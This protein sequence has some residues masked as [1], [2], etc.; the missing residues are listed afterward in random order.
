MVGHII[1]MILYFPDKLLARSQSATEVVD[2]MR[3]LRRFGRNERGVAAVEFALVAPVLVLLLC[4]TIAASAAF[5][6]WGMM[7]GSS[8]Y[9]A[10]IMATG[11]VKNNVSGAITT[12]NT[13]A[14]TTCSS[15]LPST[16]VEY[17]ACYNL[18]SWATF[19]VT[20]TEN[21][22][23][24]SVTVILSTSAS[25]AAIADVMKLFTGKTLT[26]TAVVMKEGTCP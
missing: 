5:L 12:S 6:T 2:R 26:S 21:C 4:G 3:R 8:Q 9:G 23:I 10:R 22:T 24:P 19:T 7:Q 1:D 15:A 25:A 16:D 17:Y 18:P 20:T 13:S 14:T 11:T